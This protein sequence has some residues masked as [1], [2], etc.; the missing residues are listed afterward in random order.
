M[1]NY[2]EVMRRFAMKPAQNV[3]LPVNDFGSVEDYFQAVEKK[4][5][6]QPIVESEADND[7]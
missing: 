6:V 5:D 3:D 7:E 1:K 2:N 4:Y